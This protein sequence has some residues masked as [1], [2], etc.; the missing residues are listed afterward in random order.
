MKRSFL[1][2][3]LLTVASVIGVFAASH[4]ASS[5]IYV[6]IGGGT[7]STRQWLTTYIN[8]PLHDYYWTQ[9]NQW[10]LRASELNA[11]GMTPGQITSLA[12]KVRNASPWPGTRNTTISMKNT[13]ATALTNPMNTTGMTVVY[14]NPTQQISAIVNTITW[15]TFNFQT[16]FLWDGTSNIII[17]FCHYRTAYTYNFPEY[18]STTVTG[19][20][21]VANSVTYWNDGANYCVTTPNGSGF[22]TRPVMMFGVLSGIE[23]SF[24]DDVD[25]RRI[26][27]QGSVYDGIDPN[28]PKP[29]LTFRQTLNQNINLTYRI[30]G[31]LPAENVVYQAQRNGSSTMNHIAGS[32]G[33]FTYTM[34]DATGP[35]AGAG[36]ALNLT[37]AAGGSYRLEATYQIPGYTQTWSKEFSIAFP[38]DLMVRQIRSPL[39]VP[40]KY[41]RGV[42]IPVSARIQNV[43]L[44]DVTTA[45]VIATIRQLPGNNEVYRDTTDYLGLL[46]TGDLGTID[47]DNF[48][49]LEVGSWSLSICAE[50]LNATDQQ[51]VN[52]CQPSP[53][54]TYIFQTL[55]NEEVG[56]Q[57]IEAPTSAGVY[58]TRRPFTPRGRIING[59]MQDLS[60]IP[61]RM[62]IFQLPGRVPVYNQVVIVPDVGADAPL[63]ISSFDFPAFVPQAAGQYE[64]C[65][66]TEYPGDPINTNNQVCQFFN[67]QANLS[68]VYTI[69]TLKAG[70]PRNYLTMQAAADD[71]YR[72]GV[73]GPVEF[74][75]TDAAYSVGSAA[76]SQPAL[77]LTAK[78]IGVDASNPVTFKPSLARS[79]N[80]GSIVVTLNSGSGVGVLL[81]QNVFASN[82]N[83]VQFEFQKD[84]QWANT[85]GFIRFDGGEQ[86][87]L[88]FELNASTPFR[89]PFYLGDGSHD[90]TV[91][92]CIIRNSP[93]TTPS[94]VSS[95]PS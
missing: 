62:Q 8:N 59:G 64:V 66:T 56:S 35:F 38:N 18:E 26:L 7:G 37:N 91:K 6:E 52:D 87:S 88:V 82:P 46:A 73:S 45:R 21:G 55:Y 20:T 78:I 72:K 95:L 53:G 81:G 31:P 44:N 69:G 29:S 12:F 22:T 84:P 86:K 60:N 10:I 5:Q 57:A 4:D 93:M 83:A 42:T 43:G 32:T 77:D 34:S 63:N 50:L 54:S 36:G 90:L 71:L 51:A 17:D 14:N 67:V 23:T 41:P 33:L 65:L 49:S 19:F 48:T 47:F 85:P 11:Q 80:K 58:Y 61:V 2:S 74:E 25:P 76:L 27:R 70:D 13:T 30:V 24:P 40:K 75:L 1:R 39:V 94:Y 79:I 16:N 92:N 28:F 89:A 15:V 9:R 68:G 3:I